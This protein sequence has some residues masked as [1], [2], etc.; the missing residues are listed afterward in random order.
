VEGAKYKYA[1][2]TQEEAILLKAS[3]LLYQL[4][5]KAHAFAEGN[6]RTSITSCLAFPSMNG[7]YFDTNKHQE[8]LDFV[9]SAAQGGQSINGIHKWLSQRVKRY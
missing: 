1:D 3:F 5:A 6:K 8:L 9:L 4:A 2:T 7:L